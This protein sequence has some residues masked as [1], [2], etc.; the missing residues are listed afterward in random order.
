MIQLGP[1][2]A[3]RFALMDNQQ[4]DVQQRLFH[5]SVNDQLTGAFN[6]RYIDERLESELAYAKRHR[7]NLSV[8]L[9]DLDRFKSVNDTYGHQVGDAVLQH[10][11]KLAQHELRTE[12][13]FGRY[14]GEEFIIIARN[15]DVNGAFCIADRIR[16]VL[17]LSPIEIGDELLHVTV[18]AGCASLDCTLDRTLAELVGLADR[19]L[20]AAKHAGRNRVVIDDP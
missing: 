4:K 17:A 11:S 9:L 19:R 10:L 3:F 1:R 14:G 7:T 6:R 8:A 16:S 15:V 2:A 12:D 13:V 20:Y 5:S 18:S